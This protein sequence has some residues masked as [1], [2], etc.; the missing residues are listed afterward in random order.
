MNSIFSD[1]MQILIGLYILTKMTILMRSNIDSF[2]VSYI[3]IRFVKCVYFV[4][5]NSRLDN[6]QIAMKRLE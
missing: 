2:E 1:Y 6:R 5:M 4:E 3:F